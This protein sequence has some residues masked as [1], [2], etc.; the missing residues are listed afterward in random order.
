MLASINE[1]LKLLHQQIID[2]GSPPIDEIYK[3]VRTSCTFVFQSRWW[4]NSIRCLFYDFEPQV[5]DR[6]RFIH[7]HL[8]AM[9]GQKT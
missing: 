7:E 2:R 3:N 8:I 1:L 4:Y 5:F 6:I 9:L